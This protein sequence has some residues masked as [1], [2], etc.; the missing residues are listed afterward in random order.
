[1]P[2]FGI[3]ECFYGLAWAHSDREAYAHF[4]K[5]IG[6][7]FYVYAPKADARLRKHWCAE[8][9][10]QDLEEYRAM[11]ECFARRSLKFGM[12]ISPQGLHKNKLDLQSRRYLQTKI[13]QLVDCGVEI[14]GVFFDDMQS[15]PDMAARQLE[16]MEAVPQPPG[17]QVVFCPSYYSFDS[18]LDMLFGDRPA[19][20]LETIGQNLSSKVDILWT[21]EQIISEKISREHL[22]HVQATIKRKPF[23]CDNF[24]AN[25]GPLNCN[26]LKPVPISGRERGVFDEARAWAFNP[27][28]QP[29][30]SKLVLYAFSLFIREGLEPQAAFDVAVRRLCTVTTAELLLQRQ[31]Q[32]AEEGLDRLTQAEK[33]ALKESFLAS[34]GPVEQELARWLDGQY[35]VGFEAVI[36]QSGFEA[37]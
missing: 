11:R 24:F 6:F 5:D 4:L 22:Q 7:H 12:A 8:L 23:I 27:M 30:L 36:D 3:I 20:Y 13:G 17:V 9:S 18:L 37:T 33:L 14:L 29:H 28:N 25:D 32:F 35:T 21:G 31:K 15:E 34:N 26:F 10:P 16:I 19:N 1:M 2:A